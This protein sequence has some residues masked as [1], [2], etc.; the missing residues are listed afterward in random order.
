MHACDSKGSTKRRHPELPCLEYCTNN[1]LRNGIPNTAQ[2]DTGFQIF[3]VPLTCYVSHFSTVGNRQKS[4]PTIFL[5]G[6]GHFR[7]QV[8]DLTHH[9][10]LLLVSLTT[11]L[12]ATA[13][14]ENS[15]WLVTSSIQYRDGDVCQRVTAFSIFLLHV[16][17]PLAL[18]RASA[19]NSSKLAYRT[20]STLSNNPH[21]VSSA[22]VPIHTLVRLTAS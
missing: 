12:Y 20:I 5:H 3:L 2:V 16:M 22:L 19:R 18:R 13:A 10:R 14:T 11:P 7:P 8:S 9:L 15:L 21:I 17:L 4:P 1:S 6:T